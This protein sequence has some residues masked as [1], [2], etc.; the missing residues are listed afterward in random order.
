MRCCNTRLILCMGAA[1]ITLDP[2]DTLD[3]QAGQLAVF[4]PTDDVTPYFET[5]SEGVHDR[6]GALLMSSR[7][8]RR[9]IPCSIEA[10][11]VR[12]L[13]QLLCDNARHRIRVADAMKVVGGSK[14]HLFR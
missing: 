2:G 1:E 6:H 13:R 12:R 3:L 10:G 9:E 5:R 4:L 11:R 8:R 7:G 14:F